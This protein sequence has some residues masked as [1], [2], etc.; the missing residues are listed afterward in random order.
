MKNLIK[1]LWATGP[2][3]IIIATSL[4]ALGG[5]TRRSLYHL[6]AINIVFFEHLIG[7][8]V[9]LPIV[10]PSLR[11]EKFTPKLALTVFLV[12]LFGGLLGTLFITTALI[13]VNFI[14]FSVVFLIQKL[15]PLFAM[16]S[17]NL[18]LGEK[19]TKKYLQ[20]AGLALVATFFVTF[21]NGAINFD[22]GSETTI[23]ALYAL[24]AA[25]V[26]GIGTTLSK[27]L[28]NQVSSNSATVLRFYLTTLLAF[29]AS[30]IL[31]SAN[32]L[33]QVNI[34]EI[35][36]LAFIAITTGII[37]MILYYRGLSKT[38]AKTSTILELALPL[39]AVFIDMFLYKNFLAPTQYLA[40]IIL[41]Y[42]MY[43]VGK[44]ALS[45]SENIS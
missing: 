5:V 38:E 1:K 4:W 43:R 27:T 16:V 20:W 18:I 42:A 2:L 7:S 3:L 9:L 29:A 36:R 15:Q 33:T 25:V 23:A 31:G 6:P 34:G 39:T 21:K 19:I 11:K 44:L 22:T 26:W 32:L 37:A 8:L 30:F 41:M 17:A 45:E 40:A 28:L 13:K 14:A 10:I 35:S 24:G 12:A